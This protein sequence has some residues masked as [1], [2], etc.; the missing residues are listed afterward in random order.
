MKEYLHTV[1]RSLCVV[2]LLCSSL[3]V[4]ADDVSTEMPE[5]TTDLKAAYSVVPGLEPSQTQIL[6]VVVSNATSYQWYTCDDANKTNVSE[7][8]G[9][10]SNTYVYDAPENEDEGVYI[11]CVATNENADEGS[12]T[13]TSTV[14]CITAS[15]P[16]DWSKVFGTDEGTET[17]PYLINNSN[18]NSFVYAM[19]RHALDE[20]TFSTS[21]LYFRLNEDITTSTALTNYIDLSSEIDYSFDLNS[22]KISYFGSCP[23]SNYVFFD[24][25]IDL[26]NV[27]YTLT[28]GN[29]EEWDNFTNNFIPDEDEDVQSN[30]NSFT[31]TD[32]IVLDE[33]SYTPSELYGITTSIFHLNG[34][35]INFSGL[36][37]L[38]TDEET[39]ELV[40]SSSCYPFFVD[41]EYLQKAVYYS[42]YIGGDYVEWNDFVSFAKSEYL[43]DNDKFTLA[44][45]IFPSEAPEESVS[46]KITSSNFS[47]TYEG[48]DYYVYISNSGTDKPV[49]SDHDDYLNLPETLCPIF[50]NS[51]LEGSVS[52]Y[53]YL[54]D[55]D[56]GLKTFVNSTFPQKENV[57]ICIDKGSDE[58][59]AEYDISDESFDYPLGESCNVVV[60]GSYSGSG[61]ITI[62][63]PTAIDPSTEGF[64]G[65]KLFS[66]ETN[67]SG[68]TYDYCLLSEDILAKALLNSFY[69]GIVSGNNKDKRGGS[70]SYSTIKDL[71]GHGTSAAPYLIATYDMLKVLVDY[72]NT[73]STETSDMYIKLISDINPQ[74]VER[75]T[76]I[77]GE[78]LIKSPVENVQ[79][80]AAFKG[81]FDGNGFSLGG[82]T[83][84]LFST[85]DGAE[86][87]NL[88][89]VDC[90][91]DGVHALMEDGETTNNSSVSM[92]YVSG[93][94][95]GLV[96]IVNTDISITN[97]YA[98]NP[99]DYKYN[100][101]NA[102][103]AYDITRTTVDDASGTHKILSDNCYTLGSK[104]SDCTLFIP[105]DNTFYT[106]T[107]SDADFAALT[108]PYY[109]LDIAGYASD[110]FIKWSGMGLTDHLV[111]NPSK[112]NVSLLYN[113]IQSN[114][115]TV[116]GGK[117]DGCFGNNTALSNLYYWYLVDKQNL[118]LPNV[119]A[120]A[121]RIKNIYYSRNA[122][123]G[124]AAPKGLN[125]VYLPFAWNYSTDVVDNSGNAISGTSVYILGDKINASGNFDNDA[126]YVDY[127]KESSLKFFVPSAEGF[128]I[129]SCALPTILDVPQNGWAIKKHADTGWF[130]YSNA[131]DGYNLSEINMLAKFEGPSAQDG[132]PLHDGRS[133][134]DI[135]RL[136][137]T[138]D[139]DN[140]KVVD[141]SSSG[142]A[143]HCGTFTTVA[144]GTFGSGTLS[145]IQD[146]TLTC[147][148]LNSAGTGFASVTTSSSVQ[149][150]RTFIAIAPGSNSAKQSFGFGI[151]GISDTEDTAI[152]GVHVDNIELLTP[153]QSM[154]YSLDGR[155]VGQ[156]GKKL[157]S[158]MYI[159]N[160]K[161][162]VV[163]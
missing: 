88:G 161:K 28:I 36:S 90:Y 139:I 132:S 59:L 92:C 126:S 3:S 137:L 140:D 144:A 8:D 108:T 155:Y 10:T 97:S 113:V 26:A 83:K 127:T 29:A 120:A 41:D 89:I 145:D 107:N 21:G 135:N 131:F 142:R 91:M 118:T 160:G 62:T 60:L 87:K 98:F 80:S 81:H 58:S 163:K 158:G 50:A 117:L 15:T 130:Y 153:E 159:M 16:I 51:T 133:F 37:T 148:K 4:W 152:D 14:T 23:S 70:Y 99:D 35:T 77:N 1:F 136:K 157:A 30:V 102:Y 68:I 49:T 138:A 162:F 40:S 147:Y 27:T 73:N 22:K 101:A 105:T 66:T 24:E 79:F 53:Y 34:K 100:R 149:P 63:L 9:A 121:L 141:L 2:A 115:C 96:E 42:Y 18:W 84:P 7:I 104:K 72:V 95:D 119:K 109:S 75:L 38:P 5:F 32:D 156:Y 43:G 47:N 19:D 103:T 55:S 82:F 110:D 114:G 86:I 76:G 150:F 39:S 48:V 65:K 69:Q 25:E 12:Q 85:L 116:E 20:S 33:L 61:N 6:T 93:V 125:T 13:A 111:E 122:K 67:N 44:G 129:C 146:K 11:Y 31:L 52:K 143:I 54:L 74:N 112:S 94:S 57:N 17:D 128:E 123:D 151:T 71:A 124:T 45:N 154:V 106:Y 78:K 64:S 46:S 56:A 134:M